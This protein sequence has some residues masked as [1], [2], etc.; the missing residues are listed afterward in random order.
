MSKSNN[1]YKK[2]VRWFWLI[3]ALPFILVITL[4]ILIS[5]D[6]FGP[7]PTFEQLEN[8]DNNLAAEVYSSDGVLLG[9]FYLQNRSWTEYEEI[10]PYVIDALVATEDIRFYRHSGVDF[11]GLG[12]V[13]VKSL[14]MGKNTGG[15]STISQQLAKNLYNTRAEMMGETGKRGIF[16][17]GIT[18]FK[19]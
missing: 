6:V 10:S 12:R 5:K 9:K 16:N 7:M 2:Y 17:L 14:L 18:K 19:E 3:F 4:F 15:G 8:P 11:R 1:K 13:F